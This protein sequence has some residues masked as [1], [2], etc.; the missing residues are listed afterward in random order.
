MSWTSK[1]IWSEGMF[2]RPQHFQQNDR[3]LESLI[4]NRCGP[5]RPY[6]WGLEE[7]TIN[8][9]ALSLGKIEIAKCK[10]ILPDGTTIDIPTADKPPAPIKPGKNTKDENFYLCLMEKRPNATE[11]SREE[12]DTL[13]VRYSIDATDVRDASL[14]EDSNAPIELGRKNLLLLTESDERT[15]YACIG[16]GRIIEIRSDKRVVLDDS[17]IGSSIDCQN[18]MQ[19]AGYIEEI[20]GLLKQRAE[21]IA[22]RLDATASSGGGGAAQVEDYMLLQLINGY[23]SI[24]AHLGKLPAYHPEALFQVCLQLAGELA[25]FTTT[26]HRPEGL[27]EYEHTNLASTFISIMTELRRSLGVVF[28]HSAQQFQFKHY[29]RVGISLAVISDKSL[30][31]DAVFVL[32]VKA[33]VPTEKLRSQFPLQA[34]VGPK[35]TMKQL[36]T[37]QLPGIELEALSVAPR[38]IPFHSGFSYFELNKRGDMWKKLSS[39]AGL[40][41]HPG[42]K[43]PGL[44]LELWAIRG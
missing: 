36:I 3:Y 18:S 42:G 17:F 33:D 32:A 11:A 6:A 2:L 4:E 27:P 7:L 10:A 34:K 19:L 20:Q 43:Y 12:D 25:T 1:I 23:E 40:G 21:A 13:E 37:S 5:L 29:K 38:Q 41:L 39:S 24:F 35:E 44:E 22:V 15:E 26:K 28:E 9:E 8:Q 30:F 31:D 16:I 14:P